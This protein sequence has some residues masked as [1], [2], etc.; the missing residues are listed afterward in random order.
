MNKSIYIS[1]QENK[2]SQAHLITASLIATVITTTSTLFYFNSLILDMFSYLVYTCSPIITILVFHF[3][4]SLSKNEKNYILITEENILIEDKESEDHIN[5][6]LREIECFETRFNEIIFHT[7]KD[8]TIS[9]KLNRIRCDK[10]RWEIK[11]FLRIHIPHM[12]DA[13]QQYTL[14]S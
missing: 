2:I 6:P 11:E 5:L 10:K 1:C 9:L 8:E 3:Y 14:A 7:K 12:R 4:L 13:H